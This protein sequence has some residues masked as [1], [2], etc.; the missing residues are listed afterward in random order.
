MLTDN[1]ITFLPRCIVHSSRKF[2]FARFLTGGR[3]ADPTIQI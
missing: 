2:R 1:F 3:R